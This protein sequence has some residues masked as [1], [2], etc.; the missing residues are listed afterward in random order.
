[1]SE[2]YRIVHVFVMVHQHVL[3][4]EKKTFKLQW[5]LSIMD[6]FVQVNCPLYRGVL[7]REVSPIL[8]NLYNAFNGFLQFKV[9]GPPK[10][11]YYSIYWQQNSVSK[12][13][14]TA[15]GGSHDTYLCI[16]EVMKNLELHVA[17]LSRFKTGPSISIW[18]VSFLYSTSDPLTDRPAYSVHHRAQ[19]FKAFSQFPSV[20]CKMKKRTSTHETWLCSD[21]QQAKLKKSLWTFVENV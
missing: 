4:H 7:Y 6:T 8:F 10:L 13:P 16:K 14:D 20:S 1:M 5:N 15:T 21:F 2:I 18:Y 9:A 17:K 11:I 3:Y 19:S 12:D